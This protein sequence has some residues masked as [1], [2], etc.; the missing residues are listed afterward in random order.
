MNT[1]F[2]DSPDGKQVAYDLS[3]AGPAIILLHGGGGNRQEWHDAGYVKRLQDHFA[4]I[5]LDLRGHGESSLPTEPADYTVDKMQQDIL[6]VADA[7]G[8][9]RFSLWA[10][11]YGGRVGRYL[12]AHSER[13]SRIVLMSTQLGPGAPGDLRQEV[14]EFC[15]H[16]PPILQAERDGILDFDSLSQHDQEFLRTFNVPVM[17]GWGRAMLDWPTIKPVDFLCPALWLIGSE[18]RP[19]MDS[20]RQFEASL[21]GSTVQA[22][23]LEGLNHGQVFEEID[24]V[25]PV[26]LAFTQS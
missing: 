22:Q 2:A 26:M 15:N 16:W 25:F 23:I 4:V 14:L 8:F 20:F 6:A 7:C 21:A 9:E 11:S 3:G 19:V 12:A 17:L 10:M 24:L 5:T 1:R 18:D 13:V